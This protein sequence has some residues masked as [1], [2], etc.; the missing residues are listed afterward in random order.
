MTIQV[1]IVENERPVREELV[2]LL[3]EAKGFECVGAYA[4]GEEALR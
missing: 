4:S 3:K 1:A 2:S